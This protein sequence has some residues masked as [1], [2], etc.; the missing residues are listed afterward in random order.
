MR[1]NGRFDVAYKQRALSAR[2]KDIEAELRL[3]GARPCPDPAACTAGAVLGP[4]LLALCIVAAGY[5]AALL[6]GRP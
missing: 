2:C 1:N 3:L 6:W 4:A 5:V